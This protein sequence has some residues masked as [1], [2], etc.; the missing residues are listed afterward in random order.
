MNRQDYSKLK[1]KKQY[2]NPFNIP[3]SLETL[4]GQHVQISRRWCL[5]WSW[6]KYLYGLNKEQPQLTSPNQ[7]EFLRQISKDPNSVV[8]GIVR[9]KEETEKRVAAEIKRSNIHILQGDL[10]DYESLK[11]YKTFPS[12][13]ATYLPYEN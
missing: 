11:V 12:H 1:P 9:N 6:G 10:D 3:S 2:P 8:I 5:S 13:L 7:F 4:Y